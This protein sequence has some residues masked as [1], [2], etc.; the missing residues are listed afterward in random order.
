MQFPTIADNILYCLIFFNR[1]T[2]ILHATLVRTGAKSKYF[3]QTYICLGL[4][5]KFLFI[6]R[7]PWQCNDIFNII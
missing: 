4:L 5:D 3:A 7:L 1:K 6:M 2:D